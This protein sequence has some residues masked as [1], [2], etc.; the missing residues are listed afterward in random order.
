MT[1]AAL[2]QPTASPHAHDKS[3]IERI[4][5]R[6]CLALLPVT[7]W[8]FYC[9]GWPAIILWAITTLAAVITEAGCLYL[10]GQPLSRIR[11]QSALLTGWMLALTLPPWAPWW[12]GVGGAFFAIAI[13]KQI[14]GGIGQNLFN[15]ALLAR[16]ALLIS[17]PVQLTTWVNVTPINSVA[18]PGLMEAMRII[19]DS[20]PLADG[21]TGATWLG[22]GKAAA[23]GG[24]HLGE[25]ISKDF[26]LYDAVFG[27]SR[28]SM[29]ETSALLALAGGLYLLLTRVISWHIPLAM[30]GSLAALALATEYFNPDRYAGALYHLTSGGVMIGAFF[31]ATE[32]VTSPSTA[33][34]KLLFGIGCGVLLFAIR[35]WGGFPEA[36]AFAILL[37]NALTPLIDRAIKPRAYGR[38]HAG[39]AIKHVSAVRKVV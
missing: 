1:A 12:V 27:F 6:V 25:M 26:S 7:L 34:G 37:M 11:D 19:F 32:Y 39:N 29:G 18:A 3:S 13:G 5:L 35:S 33:A 23:A 14:Y 20:A 9:F 8:G 15:P 38:N 10:L 16:I 24:A 22:A 4:M 17:F 30:L 28:G 36:V 31:Y 2:Y 21:M